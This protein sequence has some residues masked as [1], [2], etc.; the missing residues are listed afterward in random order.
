M[1]TSITLLTPEGTRK[2]LIIPP[3]EPTPLVVIDGETN[4]MYR[5]RT[6]ATTYEYEPIPYY[7]HGTKSNAL[8]NTS[9]IIVYP[10]NSDIG[11]MLKD[12]QRD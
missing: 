7:I 8:V 12:E 11:A 9:G 5:L 4:I 3:V 1:S 6:S 2:E 10:P